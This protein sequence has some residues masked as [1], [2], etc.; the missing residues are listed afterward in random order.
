MGKII[1]VGEY[2]VT[3]A[4]DFFGIRIWALHYGT[5]LVLFEYMGKDEIHEKY[6]F[7]SRKDVKWILA[8]EFKTLFTP[9][10]HPF[11]LDMEK[12]KLPDN[13]FFIKNKGD[14][15]ANL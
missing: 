6:F 14:D 15:D 4:D 12:I 10:F 7:K 13:A 5:D 9:A 1:Q 8:F 2:S 11:L 3:Q